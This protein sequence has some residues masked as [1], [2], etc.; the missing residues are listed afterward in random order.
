MEAEAYL[1][2]E[3]RKVERKVKEAEDK[4]VEKEEK[5]KSKKSSGSKD[6]D[7]GHDV[8]VSV[9]QDHVKRGKVF[10]YKVAPIFR[11]KYGHRKCCGDRLV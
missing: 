4:A 10:Y 8:G 9:D 2:K 7:K 6:K 11:R 3:R 1:E 5:K